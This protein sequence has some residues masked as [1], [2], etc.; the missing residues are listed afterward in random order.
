MRVGALPARDF[1]REETH[2]NFNSEP[3]CRSPT[4]AAPHRRVLLGWFGDCVPKHHRR[5]AGWQPPGT[6][7]AT[8]RAPR[9]HPPLIDQ[10]HRLFSTCMTGAISAHLWWASWQVPCC[11]RRCRRPA[12]HLSL[13]TRH[14]HSHLVLIKYITKYIIPPAHACSPVALAAC[15]SS[16]N[17]PL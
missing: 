16:V 2:Q 17:P 11:P 14:M 15:G 8:S 9:P 12:P 5:L 6:S 4:A 10:T 1:R 7:R 13:L 3:R